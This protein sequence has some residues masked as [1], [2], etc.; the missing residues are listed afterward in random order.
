LTQIPANQPP[1]VFSLI[2]PA[3]GDTTSDSTAFQWQ[4]PYDPNLGDQFRYDL[5][6][7]TS[8]GF[9]SQFTTID[10]NLVISEFTKVLNSGTY[11]WKVKAEDNW[12][13]ATWSAQ[14]W[15]F[16]TLLELVANFSAQPTTGPV[17]LVVNFTDLTLGNPTSWFWYFGDDST[18]TLPDPIHIYRDTGY[19]DVK[20]VVS[21]GTETDSLIRHNYIQ[22]VPPVVADFSGNPRSGFVS[23]MVQ[24]TDSS[25]GNPTSWF[26]DFGD[27]STSTERNPIHTYNETGYFSVKLIASNQWDSDTIIKVDY[28]HVL[29]HLTADFSAS[30]DTGL[31]P[32]SVRFTDLSAGG[33]TS[34]LWHFGDGDSS[35]QRNPV[36]VYSCEDTGYFDVR[37]IVWNQTE[38]DTLTK[39]NCIYVSPGVGAKFVAVPTSGA[40]PLTVQFID[41]S[42]GCP[43]LWLWNFGDDSTD[44]TQNP[45]HTYNDTGYYDVRLIVSNEVDSDTMIKENYIHVLPPNPVLHWADRLGYQIDGV[46]PDTGLSGS[47]FTFRVVYTDPR[48]FAPQGGYPKVNI[49]LNGDGDFED[50]N[51]GSFT[52]GVVNADTNYTD[53]REYLYNA[54]LP[55]S[56][57][58]Q[59]SFSAKNSYGLDAVGEP[60]ILKPGPMI[61]DPSTA[62]DLYIYASDITFS[63][64]HP[65]EGEVFTVFA[66][67][68]NN[69][70]SNL[71]NVSVTF[72]H[73]GQLLNQVF[74]PNISSRSSATTSIPLSFDTKGFYPI[75]VVVDEENSFE[76]WNELN[77]FAIRPIIVGDYEFPGGIVVEAQLNSPVYPY[78]WITVTGNA[79]YTPEYLGV[80][81]GATVTITIQETGAEYTTYTNDPGNFSIGFYGPT[82]A[83]EY[84]VKVEVTD[85]TLID[86][87]ILD[88]EVISQPG[89]DLAIRINLSETDSLRQNEADTIYTKIFNFGSEDAHNFSVGI[90]KDA[91]LYHSYWVDSLLAGDSLAIPDTVISF[92]SSGWHTVSGL[93]DVGDSV[94]E[95]NEGNNISTLS[96]YVWCNGPDLTVIKVV[97]SDSA[98]KG[99]QPIKF[100]AWLV[101]LG[102]VAV[103]ETFGVEFSDSIGDTIVSFDTVY[104]DFLAPFQSETAYVSTYYTYSDTLEHSFRVFADPES[105]ITECDEENNMYG[106]GPCIDLKVA[107]HDIGF[108]DTDPQD[109]D[110]VRI[111][112]RVFNYGD[113]SAFN[114]KVRFKIDGNQVGEDITIPRIYPD[115]CVTVFSSVTWQFDPSACSLQV[116]CDPQN[117][118]LECNELNNSAYCPLPY[119]LYLYYRSRCP[120]E[121]P[122]ASPYV[123]STCYPIVNDSLTIFGVLRNGGGFD[124]TGKIEIE[125]IDS[126]EG[127]LGFITVDSVLNHQSNI[128][129]GTLRHAFTYYGLHTVT[130]HADYNDQY[131]ECD[132]ELNNYYSAS[133]FVDS[134]QPDLPDLE[135]R[136]NY[137]EFS[138]DCPTWGDTLWFFVTTYNIGQAFAEN[139]R[140][141][142][143]V[144]ELLVGDDIL[145]DS[146]PVGPNNYHTD[147]STAPW[148]VPKEFDVTHVCKI[149]VDPYN[150]ILEIREDNNEATRALPVVRCGDVNEDCAVTVADVVYLINYLFLIP[151]GPAPQPWAAGDVNCDGVINVTDV[152]YLINYLFLVPL[153][154]PPGC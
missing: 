58:C 38:R 114:S 146:I 41:S 149:V 36:H 3:D 50:E 46:S 2:S 66:T 7:S 141:R 132:E 56:S 128:A 92:D 101:N 57:D 34:W 133:I 65:D 69:S 60:T 10:S 21:N 131:Y 108:S 8:P 70:D 12:G 40:V 75:K 25:E 59:Y 88:L 29:P 68:H 72:Y 19:Y 106:E 137:I 130:L 22:V 117:S 23:L 16:V 84:S 100:D 109:G 51:E 64:P 148:I 144:D 48:N 42:L 26:W 37:L 24:F 9:E 27:D 99:E 142:F 45:L 11:F 154:P 20:L 39:E 151:P 74:I 94:N 49:D 54:T 73:S 62:L 78:S 138:D 127:L 28:I 6:V 52:M 126:I 86:S 67:I 150:E 125:V 153:G 111:I 81:S 35:T 32:L 120:Q 124:V 140:I 85:Y 80:V 107:Y 96:L 116:E 139:V 89:V 17:P 83:G 121:Y 105:V 136:S 113:I 104:V 79:H 119:D 4:I 129:S 5:Y 43:T 76:E 33:P 55:A 1:W 145:I 61:L 13:A 18:S 115:S 97:F 143:L 82:Q 98:S 152:V 90:Y 147:S 30:P 93:V 63:D 134:L 15:S 102:G 87:T 103:S 77:N 110:T 91:L 95:Y 123:F 118:I 47:L 71:T 44:T 53:G 135:V 112:A 14:T 31:P 122:Y